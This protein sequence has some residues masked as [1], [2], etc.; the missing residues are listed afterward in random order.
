MP[1]TRDIIATSIANIRGDGPADGG[2]EPIDAAP[3]TDNNTADTPDADAGSP[4]AASDSTPAA[5]ATPNNDDVDKEPEYTVDA[6]GREIVNRIPHPRVKTMVAHAVARATEAKAR[7][8]S[9]AQARITEMDRIG[10]IMERDPDRFIAMLQQAHPGYRAYAKAGASGAAPIT[11][12][13]GDPRP[14]PD[15]RLAD[16]TPAYSPEGFQKV[17]EWQARQIEQRV[18]GQV[19]EKYGW[20]DQQRQAHQVRESV[21]PQVRQQIADATANWDGFTAHQD[22]ILAELRADSAEAER[23]GRPPRLSLHDAYRIVINRAHKTEREKWQKAPHPDKTQPPATRHT[24]DT[25][26]RD[27]RDIIRAAIAPLKR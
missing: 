19:D 10:E 4:D 12:A 27:T 22:A 13:A 5:P 21:I 11:P 16:G 3:P 18:L 26:P 25:E 24:A 23:T 15:A 17:Q 6:D 2:P 8:L 14:Q 9:T 1:D 7:E 20:V